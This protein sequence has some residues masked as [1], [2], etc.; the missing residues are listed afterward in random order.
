MGMTSRERVLT[1]MNLGQPDRVPWVESYIHDDLA[2]AIVGRPVKAPGNARIAA[3]ALEV[4][5]LDNISYNL[6][7][8]DL[9]QKSYSAG[10]DFIG[11]GLI[12]SWDDFEKIKLPDPDDERLYA[13]AREYLRNNKKDRLA[14]AST[15]CGIANA[16]L[17]MG[18]ESFSYALYDDRKLVEALLDLFTDWSR[19][20][21]VHLNDLGFDVAMI[22]E[23]LGGKSGPLF[24]PK[25][26]RELFIP[27]MRKVV[28]A[29]KLPWIWHSDGNILP[30]LDDMLTL[31]MKVIA[32]LEP[33]AMDVVQLKKD[34]GRRVCLMGSIDLHYTLTMKSPAEVEH[35]VKERIETLG[36]GGG[37]ILASSNGLANYCKP[38]NIVAMSRALEKYGT[39]R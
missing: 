36:A 33:S 32:N 17:S 19:R 28:E 1:A 25:V 27:R 24:S 3:E 8:P 34:Y 4:L 12:K 2:S 22:A 16:Y 7:P 13:P 37:Y 10:Q 29:L 9:A 39:Y 23:D 14:V 6:K 38:E 15:R 20:V 21:M 35:E 11:D 31:G 30:I 18:I 5:L 26:V